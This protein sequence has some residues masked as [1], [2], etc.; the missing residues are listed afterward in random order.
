MLDCKK[1]KEILN[2]AWAEIQNLSPN[3]VEKKS[4]VQDNE[5]RE[6]IKRL[7][8]SDT[9][10]FRYAILTQVLAKATDPSINCLSLQAKAKISEPF[11]ARS[12]CKETVV[13]FERENLDNILGASGDPYVSKPLRHEMITLDII[14]HIKDKQGWKDLY[15]ILEQIEIKKDTELTLEVLKQ[16]LLEVR[17]QLA[18]KIISPPSIPSISMEQLKEIL[19]TYL[20]KP[21]EGIRPQSIVYALFKIFN[22]KTKTFAKINTAK[23]TTADIYAKRM[24]DIECR[25]HDDN[26]KLAIAVTDNLDTVKLKDELEKAAKNNVRNLLL[27]G[28]KIR[29]PKDFNSIIRKYNINIAYSSLVEFVSTTTVMLNNEMR[30][31]LVLKLYEVL[32]DLGH[33]DHLREWDKMIKEKLG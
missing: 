21:S 12:F 4:F 15:E 20:N 3:E 2:S 26:L 30:R 33:H 8:N 18:Q 10:S 24:A 27:I 6:K 13:P 17:K 25:D 14:E 29:N 28:H 16:I 9:K 5:L 11:D 31:G 23:A 1:A 22:E 32:R 7:V 19:T